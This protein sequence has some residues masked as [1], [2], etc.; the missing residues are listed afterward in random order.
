MCILSLSRESRFGIITRRLCSQCFSFSREWFELDKATIS[1][2]ECQSIYHLE[3]HMY[4][5][6]HCTV[7][8]KDCSWV[9]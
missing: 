8:F 6:I 5:P 4:N 2:P 7:Q 3:I 1:L 9:R